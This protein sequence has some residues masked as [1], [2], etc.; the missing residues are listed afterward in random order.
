MPFTSPITYPGK[1]QGGKRVV[2][3]VGQCLRFK[4]PSRSSKAEPL[5]YHKT[6]H[7]ALRH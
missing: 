1:D 6:P 4:V 3:I 2:K 5:G 7:T